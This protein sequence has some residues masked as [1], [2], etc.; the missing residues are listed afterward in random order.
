MGEK[1]SVG[2]NGEASKQA[3]KQVGS[4]HEHYERRNE[5]LRI[6]LGI[7]ISFKEKCHSR[8]WERRQATL[9]LRTPGEDDAEEVTPEAE[10]AA[11]FEPPE[12]HDD[13][14]GDAVN[15]QNGLS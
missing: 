8:K 12:D 7:V 9:V 3:S 10:E 11:Q 5:L 2:K 4:R 13:A 6:P 1:H 15:R 14:A